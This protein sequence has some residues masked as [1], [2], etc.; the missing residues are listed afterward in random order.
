MKAY[1]HNGNYV[2]HIK[3]KHPEEASEMLETRPGFDHVRL[4]IDM[5]VD[6]MEVDEMDMDYLLPA[7]TPI[8]I[9]K[10]EYHPDGP[11]PVDDVDVVGGQR[12]SGYPNPYTPFLDEHEF[13][14]AF[15]L[16]KHG[17][18]KKAIDDIMT[19]HTVRSNLPEGHFKSAYTLG[20]KIWDLE[21]DGIGK[22]WV[23]S[24]IDYDTE[25][26]GTPYYW[27]D[28]MKVVEELLQNSS[29]RDDLIY[30]PC[31]L[32]GKLSERIYG[33]LNT[34]DWWWNLQ[35]RLTG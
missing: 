31:K 27:R 2:K 9:D 10:I 25:N 11:Q 35:V 22:H 34:G 26:P 3:T 20:K 12:R 18:S 14:F 29:Y 28:P 32:A 8:L 33:D 21:P 24:K 5:E 16:V 6:E 7:G 15:R 19:L 4:N 23:M 1:I 13:E 17:I 30:T